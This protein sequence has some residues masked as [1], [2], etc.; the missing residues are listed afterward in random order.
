M[1]QPHALAENGRALH[2]ARLSCRHWLAV[3]R[4]T[5]LTLPEERYGLAVALGR[6]ARW[7]RRA[8]EL[9]AQRRA[10]QARQAPR[11]AA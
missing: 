11:R 8:A 2:H 9:L 1:S 5:R 4:E 7:R 6:A 3:A 10:I